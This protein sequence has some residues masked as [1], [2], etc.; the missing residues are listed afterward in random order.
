MLNTSGQ[1]SATLVMLQNR[2][3]GIH[4]ELNDDGAYSQIQSNDVLSSED[5][6]LSDVQNKSQEYFFEVSDSSAIKS[7]RWDNKVL[8][9]VYVSNTQ[10]VYQ[11]GEVPL[12]LFEEFKNAESKG[13]FCDKYVKNGGFPEVYS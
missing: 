8:S 13:K 11:W 12:E 4:V 5:S 7:V 10:K 9:V 3:P 1:Y 2:I 6:F